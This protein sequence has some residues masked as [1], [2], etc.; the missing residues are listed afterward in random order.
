ME[1]VAKVEIHAVQDG[2]LTR[3]WVH[4]HGMFEYDLPELEMRHVP[5]FLAHAAAQVLQEVCD[6]MLTAP[7]PVLAGQTMRLGRALLRF[8][9]PV[10]IPGADEHYQHPCLQIVDADPVCDCCQGGA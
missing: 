5:L 8:V 2:D 7:T 3:G 4:T 10:P 9:T 1:H 6:Y